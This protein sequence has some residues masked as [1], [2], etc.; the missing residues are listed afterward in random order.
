MGLSAP[1]EDVLADIRRRDERDRN[2][3]AAPLA[4]AEDAILLDTSDMDAG[5]AVAPAIAAVEAKRTA[6][7]PGGGD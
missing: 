6:R 7:L 2:R 4:M 1:F 5:R 3:A